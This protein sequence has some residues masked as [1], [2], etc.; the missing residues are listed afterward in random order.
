[1]Y[2]PAHDGNI[3]GMDVSLNHDDIVSF[4]GTNAT[5]LGEYICDICYVDIV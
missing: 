4:V 2:G 1:M 3:P 5:V